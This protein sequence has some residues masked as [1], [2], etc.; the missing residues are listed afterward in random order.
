MGPPRHGDVATTNEQRIAASLELADSL[1]SAEVESG[2]FLE[3]PL[4]R[5]RN[6]FELAERLTALHQHAANREVLPNWAQEMAIFRAPGVHRL[7]LRVYNLA[8]R[9]MR[10]V[11]GLTA[12]A[13]E[14]L[15]AEIWVDEDDD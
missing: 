8:T 15:A 4:P 12:D 1:G 6:R 5:R 11:A 14:L 3:F 13:L 7:A 10:S 2:E 9:E